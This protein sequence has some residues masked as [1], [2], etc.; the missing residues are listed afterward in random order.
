[1]AYS[2][3]QKELLAPLNPEKAAA[4]PLIETAALQTS[5]GTYYHA[6]GAGFERVLVPLSK[7]PV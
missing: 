5:E 1:M 6:H 7:S 2:I 4:M 3:A